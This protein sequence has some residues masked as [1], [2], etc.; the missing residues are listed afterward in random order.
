LAI[1]AAIRR[2]SSLVSSL[3]LAV[4]HDSFSVDEKSNYP[5]TA[6][7]QNIHNVWGKSVETHQRAFWQG[8][9]VSYR[10][11][12]KNGDNNRKACDNVEHI[13]GEGFER[14]PPPWRTLIRPNEH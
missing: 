3:A 4:F 2:A 8:Q 11:K 12:V 13:F 6:S 9:Y 7:E 10:G 5:W 14:D 1:F